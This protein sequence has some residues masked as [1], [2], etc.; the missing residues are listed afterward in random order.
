MRR[1]RNKTLFFQS[2][3]KNRKLQLLGVGA[4]L[5]LLGTTSSGVGTFFVYGKSIQR[6]NHPPNIPSNP[7]PSNGAVNVSIPTFLNWTG[8]DPDGDPVT[9]DVYFGI[10]APPP[11]ISENQTET[12]YDPGSLAYNALY[13]W[14]IVA[15]DNQSASTVGPLW[16][17]TTEKTQNMPPGTP[18]GINPTWWLPGYQ[19]N[20][21]ISSVDPENDE[22]NYSVNWGDGTIMEYG[23][24]TSGALTI[25]S[26]NWSA[27]GNYTVNIA[28]RDIYGAMSENV[29]FIIHIFEIR[30]YLEE[31]IIV[32]SI[33]DLRPVGDYIYFRV[34]KIAYL[35]FPMRLTFPPK[36]TEI[37]IVRKYI[38]VIIDNNP[39]FIF[40][41]F[42]SVI[43]SNLFK[44]FG[45]KNEL[46]GR[47]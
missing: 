9:Y 43:L 1:E 4:I 22:L 36:D 38:G 8:G 25:L 26:H 2:R 16:N 24:F 32:G 47:L 17:F 21:T 41:F 39:I 30:Q 23:P 40:G 20:L 12:T 6:V 11:K 35:H 13:Y 15:W 10:T 18:T 5:F 46:V 27:E 33:S 29:S 42:N 7:N 31:S 19:Y 3:F 34:V 14:Q 37:V 45:E 28:A 44:N